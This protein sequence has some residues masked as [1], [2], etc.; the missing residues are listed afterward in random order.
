[1]TRTY[2]SLRETIEKD[3]L[4][5]Y[6]AKEAATVSALRMLRAAI[7][8]AE[9]DHKGDFTDENV[10]EIVGRETKKLAD[11]VESFV[12]G[13]RDDMA[14]ST[15]AEMEILKKYLPAQ[16]TDEELSSIVGETIAS[17]G[18]VTAKDFGRVM[19]EVMKSAKGKADG[20]RVSAAVKAALQ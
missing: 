12:S 16:L 4:T 9:I 11:S 17:L 18:D 6:K 20:S 8:N 7:K 10:I 5:A 2:M 1:M 3:F 15:R 13:G 14:E 19:S